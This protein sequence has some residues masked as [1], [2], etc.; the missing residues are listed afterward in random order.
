MDADLSELCELRSLSRLSLKE[1]QITDKGLRMVSNLRGLKR[2][3]LDA[4][5]RQ[6]RGSAPPGVTD[7]L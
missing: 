5:Q 2:L 1:T 6:G 4:Y 7:Q 3:D